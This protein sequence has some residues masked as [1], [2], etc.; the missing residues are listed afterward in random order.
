MHGGDSEACAATRSIIFRG[1]PV[2]LSVL[3]PSGGNPIAAAG[4]ITARF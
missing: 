2:A 1:E 4:A 3:E